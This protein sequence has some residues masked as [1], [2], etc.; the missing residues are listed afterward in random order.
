M[1]KIKVCKGRTQIQMKGEKFEVAN[2][3]VNIAVGLVQRFSEIDKPLG[4]ALRKT[5]IGALDG[6]V[7]PKEE[8]EAEE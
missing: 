3:A 1:I 6:S 2:E 7:Q 5:I 4:D 8:T